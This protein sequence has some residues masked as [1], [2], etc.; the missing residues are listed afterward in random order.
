[1]QGGP[2]FGRGSYIRG[3]HVTR[4]RP[5]ASM[6]YPKPLQKGRPCDM[7]V[8]QHCMGVSNPVKGGWIS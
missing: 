8:Q 3:S 5:A 1:M 6:L 4:I 7:R 2:V